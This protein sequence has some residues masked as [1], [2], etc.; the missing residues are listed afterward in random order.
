M[1]MSESDPSPT[2]YMLP[3]GSQ[4][5]QSEKMKIVTRPNQKVGIESA[6]IAAT[7]AT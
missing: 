5:S 2:V 7:V 4:P 1:S 6:I 3:A